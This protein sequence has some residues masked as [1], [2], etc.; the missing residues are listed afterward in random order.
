M[1]RGWRWCRAAPC[2]QLVPAGEG[3][4]V[5]GSPRGVQGSQPGQAHLGKLLSHLGDPEPGSG[6]WVAPAA[7]MPQPRSVLKV[8]RL[9][10]Q[11]LQPLAAVLGVLRRSLSQGTVLLNARPCSDLS[12][13]TPP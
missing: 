6:C 13:L 1:R 2:P 12:L 4:A 3:D 8:T 10:W 11:L 5:L 7:G 9:F